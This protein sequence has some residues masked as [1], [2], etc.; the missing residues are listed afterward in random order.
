MK[1]IVVYLPEPDNEGIVHITKE[2]IDTLIDNAYNRG[3]ADGLNMQP[4][5]TLYPNVLYRSEI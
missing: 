3:V 5:P 1:P 4:Q 2:A